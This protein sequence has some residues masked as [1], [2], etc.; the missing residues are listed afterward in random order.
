MVGPETREDRVRQAF[1]PGTPRV[2]VC[3]VHEEHKVGPSRTLEGF[4]LFGRTPE[5][6]LLSAE[7]TVVSSRRPRPV[8]R[9]S[10]YEVSSWCTTRTEGTVP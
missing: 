7:R 9:A 8:P 2:P 3:V 10:T 5:Q 6:G 1:G 4:A